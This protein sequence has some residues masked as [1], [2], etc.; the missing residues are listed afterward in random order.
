MEIKTICNEDEIEKE[1]IYK[2]GRKERFLYYKC[3]DLII[4]RDLTKK[5]NPAI[6]IYPA[7]KT[8]I[9]RFKKMS[10]LKRKQLNWEDFFKYT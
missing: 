10:E 4:C 8:L 7:F 9:N 6:S 3:K 2:N 1:I 5:G